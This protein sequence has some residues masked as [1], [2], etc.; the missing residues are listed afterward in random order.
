MAAVCI[1]LITESTICSGEL[2]AASEDITG[3]WILEEIPLLIALCVDPWTEKEYYDSQQQ[4][5]IKP[6]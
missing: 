2:F 1:F 5:E 4:N 6:C 3:T